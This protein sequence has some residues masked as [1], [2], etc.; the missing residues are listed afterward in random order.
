MPSSE[1]FSYIREYLAAS[2]LGEKDRLLRQ[3]RWLVESVLPDREEFEVFRLRKGLGEIPKE[4]P[5]REALMFLLTGY[6]RMEGYDH[7]G[8]EEAF[9][10]VIPQNTGEQHPS[11]LYLNCCVNLGRARSLSERGLNLQAL[12][13]I[14]SLKPLL[15]DLDLYGPK[16]RGSTPPGLGSSAIGSEPGGAS[17]IKPGPR[18]F[19]TDSQ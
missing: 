15:D 2:L 19:S 16:R 12:Q 11:L 18:A 7:P 14:E 9:E 6:N 1:I 4:N 10:K 3:M 17:R 8:A 5:E 13:K